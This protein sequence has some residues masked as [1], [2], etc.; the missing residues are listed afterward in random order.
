MLY[1][2]T[3]FTSL[4]GTNTCHLT[5]AGISIVQIDP[6]HESQNI[7]KH[8]ACHFTFAGI[9]IV[10]IDPCSGSQN[11]SKHANPRRNRTARPLIQCRA[12]QRSWE[13]IPPD[14]NADPFLSPFHSAK[15]REH[16]RIDLL[17]SSKNSSDD[18]DHIRRIGLSRE[19]R[20]ADSILC[21][22][23]PFDFTEKGESLQR[24]GGQ[25]QER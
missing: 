11:I 23:V 1:W 17:W 24:C 22:N 13:S 6:C 7:S 21:V 5:F 18:N 20:P 4:A 8:A 3:Y 2:S 15:N 10:R 25:T 9:S 16:V 14:V 19:G 12:N